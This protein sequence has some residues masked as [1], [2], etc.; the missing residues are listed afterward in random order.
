[1]PDVDTSALAGIE[2]RGHRRGALS[3]DSW[4]QYVV[5]TTDR[6]VSYRGWAATFITPGRATPPQYLLSLHNATSSPV[7]VAV[8]RIM[9]HLWRDTIKTILVIPPVVRLHRFTALPVN[10]TAITKVPVDSSLSSSASVTVKGDASADGAASASPLT[11]TAGSPF[12]Q[13]WA[14]R[15]AVSSTTAAQYE[16]HDVIALHDGPPEIT[17]RALQGVLV[18]LDNYAATTGNPLQDRW[19]ASINWEEYTRP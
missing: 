4:T 7:V 16:Y 12:D 17:L 2:F 3:T 11:V 13:L 10:G 6:I 8:N 1:V 19:L 14:G 5:P 15:G 18:L 9:L